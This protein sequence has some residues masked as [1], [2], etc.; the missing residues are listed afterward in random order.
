MTT[1]HVAFWVSGLLVVYAYVGYPVA[2]WVSARLRRRAAAV[3]LRQWPG[4]S[5]VIPAHNERDHISA[6]IRNTLD[7]V[8]PGTLQVL[9]VSDGST[10]GTVEIIRMRGDHGVEVVELPQRRGKAAALNAG[11][12]YA[13]HDIVVFSDASIMLEPTAICRIVEPFADPLVGCVSGEDRIS[14]GGGEAVY[15]RYELFIRRQESIVHSIV[16]AS[17]CFYAQRK[18]LCGRFVP[19]LAPDFLSVLRTVEQGYRA[20]S[21]AGAVG[22]MTAVERS[23]DEFQRKVRTLLRGMTTLWSVPQL[24]NPFRHP[25]IAFELL[26]HKLL[27]WLVPFLLLVLLAA[28]AALAPESGV[29]AALLALQ[30]GLYGLAVAGLAGG[31]RWSRRRIVKAATYFTVTNVAAVAAWAK[32]VSGVRQELWAPSQRAHAR[33]P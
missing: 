33:K 23:G 13:K 6:K 19:N 14:G 5:M 12:D 16:G 4:V 18:A 32:Y 31:E 27:R 1:A 28:S 9:V 10:D 2:L 3:P 20:V 7:I 21:A 8:Y 11:L 30:I 24:L 15:G 26:S 29:F 17:G 25:I 22:A